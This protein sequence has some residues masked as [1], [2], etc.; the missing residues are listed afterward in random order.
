MSSQRKPLVLHSGT[1][2]P[3]VR[4]P[5]RKGAQRQTRE[6][7][8][9]AVSA[10]FGLLAT[11]LVGKS[12]TVVPA[13][14]DQTWCDGR[15]IY[16][17]AG[18][19]R[20]SDVIM[21]CALIRAGS[22]PPDTLHQLA[23]HPRLSRRYLM[24]EG[25]RAITLLPAAVRRHVAG[26]S[27]DI[28]RCASTSESMAL[29]RSAVHLPDPPDW[30]GAVMAVERLRRTRE[31]ED[32]SQAGRV[33]RVQALSDAR[34][35]DRGDGAPSDSSHNA[36]GELL[37]DNALSRAI[38]NM[39]DSRAKPSGGT[40]A[41]GGAG[42][43]MWGN[44]RTSAGSTPIC[45]TPPATEQLFPSGPHVVRYPEW[46]RHEGAYR[47]DWCSVAE[48]TPAADELE[49]LERPARHDRLR[50]NLAPLGL[51]LQVRRRRQSGHDLDL[52]AAIDA[53]IAFI[54]GE[55]APEAVYLD[56]I[57]LRRELAVAVMLDA[58]GSA[59]ETDAQGEALFNRQREAA[60]ALIDTFSILG[61]RVVGLA[62]RSFGRNISLTA[63]TRFDE[64]FGHGE[65]ARLG[66]IRPIG[67]TRLGAVIR[68]GTQLLL[69]EGCLPHRLQ[70][71][72]TDG[73]PYDAGYEGHYA[74]ADVT[75]AIE[76]AEA[77]GVG[78]IC[79]N[80]GSTTDTALLDRIF[81]AE[82]HAAAKDID[83]LAPQ[84]RQMIARAIERAEKRRQM[85]SNGAVA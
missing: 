44:G 38:R 50:R 41:A 4:P 58:S 11:C 22:F 36:A 8:D 39:F 7:G 26:A 30:F 75:K 85:T 61:D 59:T 63:I 25:A 76:E 21:Q 68:H 40:G 35:D 29:A 77:L 23:R 62:F 49:P 6:R 64:R 45:S 32:S 13:R 72:V 34:E 82:A 42:V 27:P 73:F 31:G 67:Y 66:G 20:R 10:R 71:L 33:E 37:R 83:A 53:S 70:I 54:S 48:W 47:K 46:D 84:M 81:G 12:M 16:L 15:T 78:L 3:S 43:K 1:N 57:R 52:D 51:G 79:L 28:P 65:M 56:K 2:V 60:A 24:L 14:G 69:T 5:R 74:T 9:E 80:L 18:A 55:V 19:D 17:A